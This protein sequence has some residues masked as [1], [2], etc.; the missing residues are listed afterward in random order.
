MLNEEGAEGT[1]FN[2]TLIGDNQ[3]NIFIGSG[4]E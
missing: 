3:D 2:D 4:G 1:A